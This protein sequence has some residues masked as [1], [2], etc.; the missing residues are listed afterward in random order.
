MSKIRESA[1]GKDCEVRLEGVCNGNPETTVLAHRNGG[2][3][4]KKR[5]DTEAAYCCSACHSAVD[6]LPSLNHVVAFE[7]ALKI[8]KFYEGIFRTQKMMLEQGLIKIGR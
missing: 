2:G 4:G 5:I 1:R 3:M 6:R 8:I 7:D